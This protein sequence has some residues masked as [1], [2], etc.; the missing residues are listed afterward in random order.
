MSRG[1]KNN[2]PGNIRRGGDTFQFEKLPSTDAAFK[3]F[4]NMPSGYRAMFVTLSTYLT[5]GHN[6]IAEIINRWA[7]DNENDTKAYIK[8]VVKLSGIKADK[9]LK[10]SD[11]EEIKQIVAAMSQVENGV[12]AVMR[13]V[14]DG[15]RM[16]KRIWI[17]P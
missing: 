2:N 14:D 10:H 6:T 5:L 12:P 8:T 4:M 7:P 1:L 11:G 13:D 3:Q 16:Q 15:F 17:K 9:E